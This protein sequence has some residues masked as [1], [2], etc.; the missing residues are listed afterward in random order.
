MKLPFFKCQRRDPELSL[1][2]AEQ[3]LSNVLNA[4]GRVLNSVP[5]ETMVSYS[6]YRKE[7][8]V[9]Q[10]TL[11][12]AMLALFL[13]LPIL[14]FA[15]EIRV[16]QTNI[17][18]NANPT[19]AISVSSWVPI[20]QIHAEMDGRTAPLYEIS[21]NEYMLQPHEN[22]EARITVRLMNRQETTVTL[23]VD[24][25]DGEAPQLISSDASGEYVYLYV[26]DA[27]SG[28]DFEGIRVVYSDGKSAAPVGYNAQ[29]GCVQL[30][31]PQCALMVRI[32]DQRGNALQIKLKP[33]E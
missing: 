5:L 15:A 13:L 7:R 10:R 33:A 9:I 29:T 3:I 16:H 19:Y 28:V 23:D 32:P 17:G 27:D 8:Y 2:D 24:S 26:N 14:F 18:E 30:E 25:V 12:A 6:N 21:E 31:Y 22:G 1:A 11:I 20:F 4:C